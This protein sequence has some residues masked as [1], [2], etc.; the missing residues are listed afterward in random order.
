MSEKSWLE[1]M[2]TPAVELTPVAKA[3][4]HTAFEISVLM[5]EGAEWKRDPA[6]VAFTIKRVVLGWINKAIL[7]RFTPC[8]EV[9]SVTFVPGQREKAMA[10]DLLM[11]GEKVTRRN[12]AAALRIAKDL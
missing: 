11:A 12:A 8:V 3:G 1:K 10:F 4:P 7:S 6:Q 2:D 5:P 9:R